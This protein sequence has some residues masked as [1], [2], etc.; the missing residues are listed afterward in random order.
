[1]SA[2]PIWN[3]IFTGTALRAAFAYAETRDH[4]EGVRA[5]LAGEEPIFTGE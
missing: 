1:M 5:F 2:R 3:P 4:Q